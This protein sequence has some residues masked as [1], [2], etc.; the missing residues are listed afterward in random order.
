[1]HFYTFPI[2]AS[3]CYCEP[4]PD[5]QVF[6]EAKLANSNLEG[7]GILALLKTLDA[8]WGNSQGLHVMLYALTQPDFAWFSV[9]KEAATVTQRSLSCDADILAKR[10]DRCKRSYSGLC[11][12]HITQIKPTSPVTIFNCSVVGSCILKRLGWCD[13]GLKSGILLAP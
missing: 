4:H 2:C 1:M 9:G 11:E 7:L 3:C 10:Y 13:K 5:A 8:A 6:L 12:C